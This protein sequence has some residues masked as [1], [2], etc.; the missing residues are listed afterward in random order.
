M[1]ASQFFGAMFDPFKR[2]TDFSGR[3]TR[4]QFWPFMFLMYA[5]QQVASYIVLMPFLEQIEALGK[6]NPDADTLPPLTIDF[7]GLMQNMMLLSAI[8][9]VVFTIPLAGALVR[10]LHDTNR[11]GYWALPSLILAIIS[12]AF[13]AYA[14]PQLKSLTLDTVMGLIGPFM[15]IGV[16]AMVMSITLIVFCIQDGTVGTNDYGSDPKDRSEETVWKP[17]PS[18]GAGDGPRGPARVITSDDAAG[19]PV[20]PEDKPKGPAR[21]VWSDD[22]GTTP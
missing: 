19:S 9:F 17:A 4:P 21:V 18:P 13:M 15:I 22:E 6:V 16:L 20:A 2:I 8:S 11:S 5:A 14:L 12:F 3:S 7:A 1:N 10:R